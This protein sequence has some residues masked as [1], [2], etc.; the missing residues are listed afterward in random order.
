MG[1]AD[2]FKTF[3]AD[4]SREY[5]AQKKSETV[6]GKIF[7][8]ADSN[9][10]LIEVEK[11]LHQWM[12]LQANETLVYYPETKQAFRLIS[13][14][15]AVMPFFKIILGCFKEDFGLAQQGYTLAHY[16]KKGS[17]L[18]STW[19]PPKNLSKLVGEAILEYDANKLM[20]IEHKT[21]KGNL[22]S[23]AVFKQHTPFSGYFFPLEVTFSYRSNQDSAEEKVVYI[24]PQFNAP[25][26]AEIKEFKI[27][28][29]VK[30]KDIEW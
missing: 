18:L 13:K 9:K 20:R 30:V 14:V 16:E 15:E 12:I 3:M 5:L 19:N 7:Y 29:G 10:L 4:F 2:I 8:E 25:L 28:P 17:V 1:Q 26:P 23:R 24:R 6:T 11:P 27:P 21:P 22:L